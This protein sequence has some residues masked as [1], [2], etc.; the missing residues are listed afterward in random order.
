MGVLV[1]NRNLGKY[2]I[3]PQA[4]P[5]LGAFGGSWEDWC[6]STFPPD[7]TDDEGNNL[8]GKCNQ[9]GLFYSPPW[10]VKGKWE[11][12]LPQSIE[13][14]WNAA[15]E[16][17][18]AASDVIGSD[19]ATAAGN[20]V[21]PTATQA[22]LNV[23]NGGPAA[24]AVF[25]GAAVAALDPGGIASIFTG[26][27]GSTGIP[28]WVPFAVGGVALLGV[29]ALLLSKPKKHAMAGYRRRARRSRRS[30]R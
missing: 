19:A 16:T 13:G 10:T 23:V 21:S 28:K 15:K 27:I 9:T 29:G 1:D 4:L 11:R 25:P 18:N 24:Q 3:G 7:A 14:L 2:G 5:Q 26:S 8:L 17:Y 12:G 22:V 6:G 30:R 20:A